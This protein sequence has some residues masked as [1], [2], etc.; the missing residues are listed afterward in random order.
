VSR[1]PR[2]EIPHTKPAPLPAWEK[3]SLKTLRRKSVGSTAGRII[4]RLVT[5]S[6]KGKISKLDLIEM[7]PFA[8]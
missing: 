5:K 4:L 8:L 7:K 3:G 1:H 6:K 2:A